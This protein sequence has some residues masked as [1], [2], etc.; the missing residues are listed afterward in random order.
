LNT[1]TPPAV[2]AALEIEPESILMISGRAADTE[3]EFAKARSAT[4][5]TV[6]V[7]ASRPFENR[8]M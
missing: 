6:A 7:Q 4:V 1:R 2:G 5:M 3:A 8:G